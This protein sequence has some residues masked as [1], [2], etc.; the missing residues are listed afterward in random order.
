MRTFILLM[1]ATLFA[2]MLASAQ[3]KSDKDLATSY[4]NSLNFCRTDLKKSTRWQDFAHCRSKALTILGHTQQ[5]ISSAP[6][7]SD[8][9]IVS[10]AVLQDTAKD[11]AKRKQQTKF[12]NILR[13]GNSYLGLLRYNQTVFF[14]NDVT[15]PL[16]SGLNRQFGSNQLRNSGCS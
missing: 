14:S 13:E 11:A 15:Q 7:K 12:C 16:I 1:L 5:K 4:Y 6:I 3:T 10:L 2:P 8:L 9:A